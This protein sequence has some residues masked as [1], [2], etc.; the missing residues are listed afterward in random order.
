MASLALYRRH[1]RAFTLVELLVVIAIIGILVMV[2]LPAINAARS[3]P[4]YAMQEQPQAARAGCGQPSQRAQTLSLVRLG[5]SV[6]GRPE[7]RVWKEAAGK[8]A[9]QLTSIP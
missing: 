2:L 3:R 8:L 4:A 9:L 1:A 6:F 5:L 7:P